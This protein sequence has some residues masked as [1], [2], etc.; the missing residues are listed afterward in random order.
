MTAGD[1]G[2]AASA[3]VPSATTPSATERAAAVGASEVLFFRPG[4]GG[5]FQVSGVG[6]PPGWAGSVCE[7][8]AEEPVLARALS[9]R[10][11][12]RVLSSAPSRI[13]GPYYAGTAVLLRVS[14]DLLA[15]WGHPGRSE[16]LLAATDAELRAL[17]VALV[18]LVEDGGPAQR[19]REELD[20]LHAVQ[21]LTTGLDQPLGATLQRVAEVVRDA[22]HCQ[23][24]VAW[25]GERSG[26]A[27]DGWAPVQGP[28]ALVAAAATA[29][30][31]PG[32]PPLVR[33]DSARDPLPPPLSPSDGVVSHLVVPLDVPG[34]GGVL[35]AHT[36]AGARGFTA[37]CQ[38]IAAQLAATASALLQV[39]AAREQVEQQ[40]SDTRLR[41]GRD[42]L[43]DVGSRHRWDEELAA[44][45]GLV[46]SGVPVAVA[47]LD[48]DDLKWVNDTHG[49]AAGDALL[50][51]CAAAVRGCLRGDSDVVARVGGDE[52]AVL[53]PRATDTESLAARLR[54]GLDAAPT[55][56]GLPVRASVGV[57][58]ALPGEKV[59]EAFAQADAA[60]Y[61]DKRRRRQQRAHA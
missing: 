47:L 14:D 2:S 19:L 61:A 3:P 48:L 38:R 50:R 5:W 36:G 27:L 33:Q 17:S 9:A 12:V 31:L 24:A 1:H 4:P 10:G 57:A 32:E 58:R 21:A 43:T 40:L 35:V 54:A 52:F 30:P 25:L 18:D 8:E 51:A 20:V 39:A 16:R 41:L 59:E 28:E 26:V 60:M 53:V 55:S 7:R 11:G 56:S 6:R 37:L 49:H 29:V 15:V 34:G 44:A 13:V 22:L 42:A 45:Q 46:D 23:V